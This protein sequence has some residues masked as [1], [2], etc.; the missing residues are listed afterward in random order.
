MF[1][2]QEQKWFCEYMPLI[3]I[4]TKNIVAV[5]AKDITREENNR[6]ELYTD[7]DT[8]ATV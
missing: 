1:Q 2:M 3:K 4:K 8:K 5:V 6:Y 7:Q